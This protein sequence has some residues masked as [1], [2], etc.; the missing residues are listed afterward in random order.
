MPNSQTGTSGGADA[1]P[2]GHVIG[3]KVDGP[4]PPARDP[5]RPC[6][7]IAPY[8][9]VVVIHSAD[10]RVGR[11][12]GLPFGR[13]PNDEPEESEQPRE[14]SEQPVLVAQ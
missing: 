13:Q 4:A 11:G 1:R 6:G 2:H 7:R 5:S 9:D 14:A 10:R 12:V 8:P 3:H